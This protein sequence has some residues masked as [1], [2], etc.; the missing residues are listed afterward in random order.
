[1]APRIS[2]GG[3]AVGEISTKSSDLLRASARACGGGMMPSCWPSF[4]A[5]PFGRLGRYL[6]CSTNRCAR[7]WLTISAV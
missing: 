1:M 2:T 4:F 5:W 6:F 3:T 7:R